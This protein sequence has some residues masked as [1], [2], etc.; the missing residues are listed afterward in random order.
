MK[1][2]LFLFILCSNNGFGQTP[3]NDPHWELVWEDNFSGTTIDN[4]KWTV[5][6]WNDNHAAKPD[7]LNSNHRPS[8]DM[9]NNVQV[10]NGTI[11]LHLKKE[12]ISCGTDYNAEVG[13]VLDNLN[14]PYHCTW[15]Y[16]NSLPYQYSS[17]LIRSKPTFQYDYGY[18]ETRCKIPLD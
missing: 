17:A 1:N 7:K 13:Y 11:K 2:I 9:A 5:A 12:V 6:D 14:N 16:N 18:Y 8:I 15:Q 3:A 4:T 10:S